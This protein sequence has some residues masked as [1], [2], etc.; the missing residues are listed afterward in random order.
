MNY[1]CNKCGYYGPVQVGHRME[2]MNAPC[3]Y[4]AAPAPQLT[5]EERQKIARECGLEESNGGEQP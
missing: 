3:P 1:F 2:T 4:Y 5:E